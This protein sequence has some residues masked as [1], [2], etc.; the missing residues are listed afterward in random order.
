MVEII[1]RW[2][3]SACTP[4]LPLVWPGEVVLLVVLLVAVRLLLVCRCLGTLTVVDRLVELAVAARRWA[5]T[6]AQAWRGLAVS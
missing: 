1:W 2:D 3:A 5:T 6:E 4:T